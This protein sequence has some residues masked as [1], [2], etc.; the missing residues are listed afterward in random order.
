MTTLLIHIKNKHSTSLQNYLNEL[1]KASEEDVDPDWGFFIDLE[2]DNRTK[3]FRKERKE[4]QSHHHHYHHH[5]HH[6]YYD[7]K[8]ESESESESESILTKATKMTNVGNVLVII[9]FIAYLIL[10]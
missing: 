10:I 2:H 1:N 4:I 9:G 6:H 7:D 5:H 8:C 3:S